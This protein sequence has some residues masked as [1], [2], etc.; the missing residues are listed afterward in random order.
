MIT[1]KNLRFL[2]GVRTK[3]TSKLLFKFRQS[4]LHCNRYTPWNVIDSDPGIVKKKQNTRETILDWMA[5]SS[6]VKGPMAADF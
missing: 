4:E 5:V 6:Q 3:R 1:S 2:V